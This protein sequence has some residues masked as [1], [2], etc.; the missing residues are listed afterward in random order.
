MEGH[1]R[2]R[3]KTTYSLNEERGI[4]AFTMH[5]PSSAAFKLVHNASRIN[6][7]RIECNTKKLA[8][9]VGTM[10]LSR[11]SRLF[12]S[13]SY[14]VSRTSV[15]L[16]R[17]GGRSYRSQSLATEFPFC[18]SAAHMICN[19]STAVSTT[20]TKTKIHSPLKRSSESQ[21]QSGQASSHVFPP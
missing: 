4:F 13:I 3:R 19:Q 18:I 12:G 5:Q 11:L 14:A 1:D 20:K 2:C 8:F 10:I 16:R 6:V 17:N 9:N 21:S 15:A 7:S